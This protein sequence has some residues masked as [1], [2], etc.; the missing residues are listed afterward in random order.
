MLVEIHGDTPAQEEEAKR[1]LF[2]I[3]WPAYPGHPWSVHVRRGGIF[4]KNLEFP[5][6]WGMFLRTSEV[7]HDAA[8]F[9]KKIIM[10]AGEW[11]ERAHQI[12]GRHEEGVE[13][14]HVEGV[15]E[16][17]TADVKLIMPNGQ[18]IKREELYPQVVEQLKRETGES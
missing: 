10:L 8:V 18:P 3:L 9:K 17:K 11:L 7:D 13:V 14:T 2:G 4:I 5:G 1:I 16:K 15:R 12:R 6:R